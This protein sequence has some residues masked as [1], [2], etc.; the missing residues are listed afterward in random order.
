[1]AT[2]IWVTMCF[3]IALVLGVILMGLTEYFVLGESKEEVISNILNLIT[4]NEEL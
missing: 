4:G 2:V 3:G 1:M